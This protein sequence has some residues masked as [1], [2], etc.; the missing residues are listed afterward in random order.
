[1]T[2]KAKTLNTEN[3][4]E[5]PTRGYLQKPFRTNKIRVL[6]YRF[7]YKWETITLYKYLFNI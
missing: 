6:N 5:E 7:V 4:K 1:M 2:N 3:L